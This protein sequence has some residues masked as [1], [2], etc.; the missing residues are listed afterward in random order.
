MQLSE[1]CQLTLT[2]HMRIET[3]FTPGTGIRYLLEATETQIVAVDT[4]RSLKFYEF[5]D[6]QIK[7][8][9]EL[10]A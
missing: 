9:N 1:G 2:P 10:A 7:E 8:E 5:I 4:H 6:K 3:S